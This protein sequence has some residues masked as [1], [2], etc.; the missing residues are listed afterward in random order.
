MISLFKRRR[1][2]NVRFSFLAL[3]CLCFGFL[4]FVFSYSYI[5]HLGAVPL[6]LICRKVRNVRKKGS[7][8]IEK[9]DILMCKNMTIYQKNILLLH[10]IKYKN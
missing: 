1:I 3:V 9:I 7:G 5:G 10:S 4:F 2:E 8:L 6:G